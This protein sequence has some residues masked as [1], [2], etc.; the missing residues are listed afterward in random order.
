VFVVGRTAAC[1]C[2]IRDSRQLR[3]GLPTILIQ[4]STRKKGEKKKM[5]K[6]QEQADEEEEEE[7]EEEKR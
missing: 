7:E 3:C 6:E 2:G 1:L 5:K 4:K